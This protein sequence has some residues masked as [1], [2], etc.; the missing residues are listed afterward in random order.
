MLKSI[1]VVIIIL[2]FALV[3]GVQ[4]VNGS[5]GR[6]DWDERYEDIPEAPECWVDGW[7]I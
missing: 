2:T 3:L 6:M 4:N 5:G 7:A 1:T